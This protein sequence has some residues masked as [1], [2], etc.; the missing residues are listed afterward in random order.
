ML[1]GVGGGMAGCRIYRVEAVN[2][3]NRALGPAMD[4]IPLTP[5]LCNP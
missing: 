4:M 5:C 1:L 3:V 2:V